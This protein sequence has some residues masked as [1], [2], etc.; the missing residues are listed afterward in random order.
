MT[1]PKSI[2]RRHPP[3]D[4]EPGQIARLPRGTELKFGAQL[5]PNPAP[6]DTEL[7]RDQPMGWW[8]LLF[9]VAIIGATF[10]L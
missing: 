4:L 9:I 2:T 1:T 8:G 5:E 10:W 6:P 7:V 3:I